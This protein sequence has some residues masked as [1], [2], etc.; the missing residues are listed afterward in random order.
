MQPVGDAPGKR[1]RDEPDEAGER[2]QKSD[3]FGA[4]AARGQ[5]QRKE[6][7]YDAE[8]EIERGEQ[9]QEPGQGGR[10]AMLL[11]QISPKSKRSIRTATTLWPDPDGSEA[12]LGMAALASTDGACD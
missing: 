3:L 11:S 10:H 7:R 2:Q 8:R 9:Q 5:K 4:H 6:R 12:T 1:S